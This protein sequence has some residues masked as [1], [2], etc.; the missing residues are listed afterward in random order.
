MSNEGVKVRVDLKATVKKYPDWVSQEDIDAGLVEPE[1]VVV[2]LDSTED[3]DKIKDF[4]KMINGGNFNGFN[5]C[6]T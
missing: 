3:Q 1:E 5:K 2:S 4:L 6:G